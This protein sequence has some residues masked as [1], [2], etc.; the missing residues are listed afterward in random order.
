MTTSSLFGFDPGIG[1]ISI[2]VHKQMGTPLRRGTV[3][4]RKQ[5][6][7]ILGRAIELVDVHGTT[8]S[9]SRNGLTPLMIW[10]A[11]NQHGGEGWRETIGGMLDTAGYAA[12]R[13]ND[14]GIRAWRHRNSPTVVFERAQ[15]EL[16]ACW[17]SHLRRQC[18]RRYRGMEP[19]A[20]RPC[21]RRCCGGK[22]EP[23]SASAIVFSDPDETDPV[24]NGF[25]LIIQTRG[26]AG[27]GAA[28]TH[29]G[30]HRAQQQPA[31]GILEVLDLPVLDP[32]VV[33]R[34][35]GQHKQPFSSMACSLNSSTV[36]PLRERP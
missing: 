29:A 35:T 2:S 24:G 33:N 32:L 16:S 36:M 34:G 15:A 10:H 26:F 5:H 7:E 22:G 28:P 1:S 11:I 13:L 31:P 19:F 25:L 30:I 12:Q 9:D 6:V 18:G 23:D 20:S 21:L 4:T 27:S 3:L 17:K 8:L 14:R